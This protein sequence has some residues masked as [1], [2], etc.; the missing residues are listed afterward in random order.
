MTNLGSILLSLK[1]VAFDVNAQMVLLRY[2]ARMRIFYVSKEFK[3]ILRS[4]NFPEK[5]HFHCLK[6]AFI[7]NLIKVGVNINYVKEIAGHSDIH[8]TMNYIHILTEDLRRR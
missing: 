3:K 6:H 5:F 1:R 7:T 2:G 4:I 8:T